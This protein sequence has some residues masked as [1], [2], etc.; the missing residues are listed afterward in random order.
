MAGLF[1]VPGISSWITWIRSWE[2][3]VSILGFL[4][5]DLGSQSWLPL[6]LLLPSELHLGSHL[7]SLC[8]QLSSIWD[9]ILDPFA[10]FASV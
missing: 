6:L 1:C 5:F 8:F 10:S 7:G 4:G 9:S 3:L 2:S